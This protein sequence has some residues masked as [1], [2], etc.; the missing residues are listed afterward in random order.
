M[1]NARVC[2]FRFAKQIKNTLYKSRRCINVWRRVF[3]CLF[4]FLVYLLCSALRAVCWFF[5][6]FIS[7]FLFNSVIFIFISK[8][9]LYKINSLVL[10]TS[11]ITH[12][13]NVL[14]YLV[15]R[16]QQDHLE[17]LRHAHRLRA[18]QRPC[19]SVV[20]LPRWHAQARVIA[21]SEQFRPTCTDDK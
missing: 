10:H 14:R 16:L 7:T 17:R 3:V 5:A 15:P 11:Q 9:T 12:I 8:A 1:G 19:R 4:V 2:V 18:E 21:R 20:H 6:Q 13:N